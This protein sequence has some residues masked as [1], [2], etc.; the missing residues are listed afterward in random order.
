M[1]IY[2]NFDIQVDEKEIARLLGYKNSFPPSEVEDLIRTEINNCSEFFSPQVIFEKINISKIEDSK[3]FLENDVVFE[4][5]FIA[6]KLSKCK[7]IIVSLATIGKKMDEIIRETFED[8]DFIKGMIKDHI[9]NCALGYVD[10]SFWNHLLEDIKGSNLG[11]TS[12]LSPGDNTWPIA[13]QKKIFQ[14]LSGNEPLSVELTESYMMLPLKSTSVVYG[15]GEDI[16]I[17]RTEH[18][19]NECSMKNCS[20]R[21]MDQFEIKV[22]HKNRNIILKASKDSNL[23]EVLRNNN[24]PLSSPCGGKGNCGKCKVT[25]S[26]ETPITSQDENHLSIEE[27]VSGIRLA[28]FL[29]VK[30]DLEVFLEEQ[31]ENMKII[32]A[33]HEKS[34]VTEPTVT[35]Q[36]IVLPKPS[37]EDCRS[38]YKR[39]QDALGLENLNINYKVLPEINP[40]IR[41]SDFKVSATLYKNNL[42]HLEAGDTTKTCFGAAIDIG[43]TTI[44]CYLVD[45]TS[46]KT[47]DIDSQINKQAP[48]GSDVI[49][50]ISYTMDIEGGTTLLRK[51]IIDQINS[52]LEGLC[53]RNNINCSNLYNVAIAGNT[54]MCHFVLGLPSENIAL[55]PFTPVLTSAVDYKGEELNIKIN[56]MISLMP[57]IS[58]YVGS[59][60]TAGIVAS[61]MMESDKYSLLLDLGTN[62][63]IVLGNKNKVFCCATAAGPAFEGAS[64]KCGMGGVKGAI[65]SV[66]LN[67]EKIY[68]TIDNAAPIGICGSAVLDIVSE[69]LKHGLIDKSGRMIDKEDLKASPYIKRM[70]YGSALREFVLEDSLKSGQTIVFSQKDIREV[71]MAKAAIAAG[72]QVLIKEAKITYE[73]I[74]NVYIAGGFGSYMN[75]ESAVTIGMIPEELKDKISAIGNSAGI[76]AKMYL[77]SE[78]YRKKAGQISE[79]AK[80]IELSTRLDFQDYYMGYMMF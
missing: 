67:S 51:L 53:G 52:M 54:T 27:I 29:T 58:C 24:L 41:S 33:G 55:A 59:D 38:D 1:T 37:T 71:Q 57:G 6:S 7:Y 17:T 68:T 16:G 26:K 19:C 63:E 49:S 14:C 42:I 39:L 47:I 74:E 40:I 62:G 5:D 69:L 2:K 56:G 64:I 79:L 45:L 43:T 18:I 10:K 3:V 4:G 25:V 80:Y 46:G 35:K 21:K 8:D 66:N 20:Y 30:S 13:E 36:H 44:A 22:H 28:C 50:R 61:G 76:G 48:Y 73:E 65:N 75:I 15:F 23:L 12:R 60:I 31:S 11:I 9:A 72:I 70:V 34:I 32:T 78:T 77:L